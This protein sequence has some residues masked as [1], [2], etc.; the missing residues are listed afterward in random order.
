MAATQHQVKYQFV[1]L[2]KAIAQPRHRVACQGGYP[3]VYLPHDHPVHEYKLRI[4]DGARHANIPLIEGPIRIDIMFSFKRKGNK[5]REFKISKPDL[6]NLD[7][8]VMDALT[9]AGV[10]GDDAQV[11]EKHSLKVWNTTDATSIF[12]SPLQFGLNERLHGA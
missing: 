5:P 1:V 8:A 11:V 2:G 7:K 9:D 6:D 3:R 12:L 10:W 4:V